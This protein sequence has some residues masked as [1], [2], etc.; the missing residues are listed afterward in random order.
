[1]STPVPPP[2]GSADAVAAAPS[3][4]AVIVGE[5]SRPGASRSKSRPG[6]SRAGGG[7]G[8]GATQ[9]CCRWSSDGPGPVVP[10]CEGEPD[11]TLTI[12][13]EDA[14]QIRDGELDPSVAYMQGKLKSTGDN[15][16]LLRIL[17]WATTPEFGKDL[18]RWSKEAQG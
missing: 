9:W 1:M 8:K 16:L 17:A 4:V 10:G 13:T 3:L 2:A 5:V 15:A 12:S 18:A 14:R 7:D 6:A 11:L